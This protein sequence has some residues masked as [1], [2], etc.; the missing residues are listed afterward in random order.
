MISQRET[1][2]LIADEDGL[3]PAEFIQ[4]SDDLFPVGSGVRQVSNIVSGSLTLDEVISESPMQLGQMYA[5]KFECQVYLEDD[6]S[7]KFIHVYQQNHGVYSD[8]F[9]GKIDSCKLDVV[10]TDRKLVA[11]DKAYTIGQM[12]VAPWWEE[13][14]T[15]RETATLKQV[16]ESLLHYVELT[17]EEVELP[18]DTFL[19]TK[20]VSLSSC[21]FTVMLKMICELECCFP[22]ISRDGIVEYII[23]N[24]EPENAV[25]LTNKI[26]RL[27]CEFE[28]FQTDTITG[29]QFYDSDNQLKWTV[30]ETANAYPIS[31]NIFLYDLNTDVLNA[32]GETILNYLSDLV[33]TPA[34]VKMI[35]SDMELKLGDYVTTDK[36]NFYI[37]ENYLS[38]IQ[39]VEQTI[40]ASGEQTMYSGTAHLDYGE[41]TLNEK[42]ARINYSIEQFNI[43]YGNF[44]ESTL[45]SLTINSEAIQTEVSRATNAEK[46]L[47]ANYKGPYVPTL[48]NA[49]AVSWQSYAV[50]KSHE[51]EVFF[52]TETQRYYRYV[53]VEE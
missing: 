3:F 49:P 20:N 44:K 25:D 38:G 8:V 21:S 26:E 5:T 31:K 53:I 12:N 11:Y 47:F 15:D 42:I 37:L 33:Y 35:V 2:I 6:L 52:N 23:L 40:S 24:T 48:Q 19:F 29:V 45:A 1:Y 7:G 22:H 10:G 34:K 28:D 4:P 50:C 14:W 32:V 27:N 43:E 36:G 16:R 46:S 17:G 51:G 13:F 39:F 41:L 18:N 9:S 30:G